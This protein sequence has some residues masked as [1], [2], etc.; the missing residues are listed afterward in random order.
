M[1]R[2]IEN[3]IY[4]ALIHNDKEIEVIVRL[5][6]LPDHILIEIEDNGRGMT[7][8]ELDQLFNRYYRG[9]NT[10]NYK[11]TGLGMSI[12]KEVIEAHNGEIQVESEVDEGTKIRI[13][14]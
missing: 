1:W 11:G 7:E 3:L 4:S 2:C 13:L 10:D 8:E 9:S 5:E 6:K 12:A 14:L